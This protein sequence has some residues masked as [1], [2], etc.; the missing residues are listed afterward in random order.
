MK[1]ENVHIGYTTTLIEVEYLDIEPG[2]VYAL[3]G[4]NGKGKSTFI[5]SLIGQIPTRRGEIEIEE[6]NVFDLNIQEKAK[7]FAF[8]QSRF[9]GVP[10]MKSEDYVGLGRTPHTSAFGKLEPKDIAVIDKSFEIL[11]IQH[12]KGRFTEELSDG[13]RQLLAIARAYAQQTKYLFLDEPTAFL[14]YTNKRKVLRI[15]KEL[16]SHDRCILFSS[17]DLEMTIAFSDELLC[18]PKQENKMKIFEA[19]KLTIETLVD[20][21]FE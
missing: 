20:C 6:K 9:N 16:A 8:V 15:L 14:D 17:H 4:A 12:L 7:Q 11:D 2:K 21:C 3:I 5:K 10:F 1:L 13:E 19:S 18:F